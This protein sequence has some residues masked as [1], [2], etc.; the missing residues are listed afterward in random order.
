MCENIKRRMQIALKAIREKQVSCKE[1]RLRA[2]YHPQNGRIQIPG[3][4]N[5]N[6]IYFSV[7]FTLN[8]V[9]QVCKYSFRK[10]KFEKEKKIL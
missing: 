1:I 9:K 6:E 3:D 8:R 4:H 5:H 2:L 10:I 7:Y